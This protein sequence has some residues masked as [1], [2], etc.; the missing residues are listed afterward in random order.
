M[1]PGNYEG[2]PLDAGPSLGRVGGDVRL[3]LPQLCSDWRLQREGRHNVIVQPG[4][5][6]FC[7]GRQQN[8]TG[9]HEQFPL[10]TMVGAVH[11]RGLLCPRRHAGRERRSQLGHLPRE[12]PLVHRARWVLAEH[13]R[14]RASDVA[15]RPQ[16][17]PR[18][19][20]HEHANGHSGEDALGQLPHECYPEHERKARGPTLRIRRLSLP[21]R[22][23]AAP[24]Q[25][26]CQYQG[27][28]LRPPRRSHRHPPR[29]NG[30]HDRAHGRGE[31]GLAAN[32]GHEA[33][34][35]RRVR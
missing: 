5:Y 21:R 34:D 7:P 15:L 17:A 28:L 12:C 23:P 16:L 13:L 25:P 22:N 14:H 18:C 30:P 19:V 31:V 24:L 1:P 20:A 35:L 4:P 8:R 10:R 3:D 27:Q 33:G 29:H 26:L 32:A 6:Q 11:A 9:A 2:S